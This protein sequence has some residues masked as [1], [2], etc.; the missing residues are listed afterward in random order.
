MTPPPRRPIINLYLLHLPPHCAPFFFSGHP[1][2]PAPDTPAG[3]AT[4]SPTR[5]PRGPSFVPAEDEALARSYAHASEKVD[6]MD[7]ELFWDLVTKVFATQPEAK[8]TRTKAALRTRFVWL[9]RVVHKYLA[10]EQLYNPK[11]GETESDTDDNIMQLYQNQNKVKNA[12]G[13]LRPAPIFK[14]TAAAKVLSNCPRWRA[15]MEGP[16]ATTLGYRPAARSTGTAPAVAAGGT[17]DLDEHEPRDEAGSGRDSSG[18]VVIATAVPAEKPSMNRPMGV[19][20]QKLLAS[21]EGPSQRS[22]E[23][24]MR[25]VASFRDSMA[26][27]QKKKNS[28]AALALEAKLVELLE[29]GPEKQRMLRELLSRTQA[30]Q[31]PALGDAGARQQGAPNGDRAGSARELSQTADDGAATHRSGGGARLTQRGGNFESLRQAVGRRSHTLAADGVEEIPPPGGRGSAATSPER[32]AVGHLAADPV[33]PRI[34]APSGRAPFASAT[35]DQARLDLG[36]GGDATSSFGLLAGLSAA[37]T[38]ACMANPGATA[39]DETG[40]G[41]SRQS[42]APTDLRG[43]A[44]SDDVRPRRRRR[45]TVPLVAASTTRGG[46]LAPGDAEGRGRSPR[47]PPA[48]VPA[49]PFPYGAAPRGGATT[50]GGVWGLPLPTF[51]P[52][53]AE[54]VMRTTALGAALRAARTEGEAA[55]GVAMGRPLDSEA[56]PLTD[57]LTAGWPPAGTV[58]S[59]ITGAREWVGRR[60]RRQRWSS[61]N[62][63]RPT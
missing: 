45:S 7:M 30:L 54:Q 60:H 10:A 35:G 24:F 59:V 57:T 18:G 37:S 63:G 36:C 43:S 4:E 14:S 23:G 21:V 47:P 31:A 49:A 62:T 6:E 25:T 28:V 3:M 33:L 53:P 15:A 52:R 34:P 22:F 61:R 2:H 46:G 41:Q 27:G 55:A 11:S 56:P 20:R 32:P 1:R 17:N 44:T 8:K 12:K 39:L 42:Q 19:K 13:E 38:G 29:D 50:G 58:D 40:C 51:A 16:S 9:R 5:P 48:E 26:A